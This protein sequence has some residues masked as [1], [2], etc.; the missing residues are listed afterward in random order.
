MRLSNLIIWA[1]IAVSYPQIT[2]AQATQV[3]KIKPLN[4]TPKGDFWTQAKNLVQE[5][6]YIVN[7]AENALSIT[8][9]SQTIESTLGQLFLHRGK[10]ERFLIYHYPNPDFICNQLSD[11]NPSINKINLSS[12]QQQLYCNLH[13]SLKQLP[14]LNQALERRLNRANNL[15]INNPL[16]SQR[17]PININPPI[18]V[19]I[20][21][22]SPDI[23]NDQIMTIDKQKSA[24]ANYEAPIKPA[25][26]PTEQTLNTIKNLRE[27]LVKTT[28][29]FPEKTKFI[30]PEQDAL[31]IQRNAFNPF[32]QESE[33]YAAFLAQPNTGMTVILPKEVYQTYDTE[34]RLISLT[35]LYPYSALETN[36]NGLIPRLS[37]NINQDKFQIVQPGLDYGIMAD[38]GDISLENIDARKTILGSKFEYLITYN[39]PNKLQDIQTEKRKLTTGKLGKFPV[40]ELGFTQAKI[41]LNRTYVVRLI[42]YQLPEIIMGDRIVKRR[43]RGRIDELLQVKSSDILVAFRPVRKRSNGSYT[44]LWKV[45]GKFADPQ[46]ED[47]ENYIKLE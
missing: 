2:L 11:K 25:F 10:V 9:D 35:E 8:I 6:I 40:N 3:N 30:Y 37:L 46:I 44:V 14:V 26:K 29:L 23:P 13:S 36:S 33:I 41:E 5:Q 34:N 45:L 28:A 4:F 47:L 22:T 1:L 20:P 17:K 42:Q 32:P 24:I 16:F 38:L 31:I 27:L 7:R 39:P 15:S 21:E 12:E 19:I 18:P 43:D